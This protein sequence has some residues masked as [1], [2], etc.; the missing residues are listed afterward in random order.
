MQELAK[1]D[2]ENILEKFQTPGKYIG[3][4][5]NC[6]IQKKNSKKFLLCF[7]DDYV[8]GMSS[9][10][11]HVVGN[12][13]DKYS[14]FSCERCFAPGPDMEK[15]M[16]KNKVE[17]F[18]LETKSPAKSFDILGFSFQFELSYTN[19][20]NM[21]DLSGLNSYRLKR[22]QDDPLII[23][24]GP[25]CV[26]PEILSNFVDLIVVG[27]AEA[28]LPELL[29]LYLRYPN[30]KKFLTRADKY[31]G[32]Y[33][34]G[35]CSKV[36]LAVYM[37][38]DNIYYPVSQPVAIV[39]IP[40]NRINIE[41]NRGCKN[42]CRF[43]QATVIY[44]PYRQKSSSQIMEIAGK[45][46]SSTGYN[47]ISLTSL[48]AT[49][50]PDLLNIMDDLHYAFRDL[51]ISVIMS[52]MRPGQFLED[53]SNRLSRLKKG[54]LTFA[55]E[56]PSERLKRIIKKNVKNS[57]IIEAAKIAAKKGWKK[58]KL[59]FMIGLPG[60]RIED[61]YE[62]I[63]FIKKIKKV[64]GLNINVTV[65]P[66]TPQPHT[67]FQWL[68]NMPP[69]I[70]NDRVNLIR[71][72][73]PAQIKEFNF[74]QYI[75]ENILTRGNKDL[76][77]VVYMAWRNGARFDQWR[78][79]FNFDFWDKAFRDTGSSWK[80]YYQMDFENMKELPWDHIDT[81]I[82]KKLLERS[83]NASMKLAGIK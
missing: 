73:A 4:E 58:I 10:G 67:P 76:S 52:S 63:K 7:P 30:K 64:S 78:E 65:S 16:R 62:I 17:L 72:N 29:E 45:C 69:E 24:G 54:G 50:H 68:R 14:L 43:C 22:K 36:K 3:T 40:H 23:G 47:E 55:P 5:W 61:I 21:M 44:G 51:G 39:D 34:S 41:I 18:S 37:G 60:E 26:N 33:V 48:S 75:I 53:L 13:I 80:I 79:Y 59:Y 46:I 6:Y 11:F 49:D 71:K 35:T 9:L 81:Y 42:N 20:I 57:D 83:Y 27:E 2:W 32:V 28:V 70:L 15:W 56:T 66:L 25:C 74:K 8:I 12:I 82:E 77:D 19:F 38:L 31:D 1:I